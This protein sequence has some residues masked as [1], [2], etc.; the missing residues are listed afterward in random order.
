MKVFVCIDDKNGMMFNKRR[1][2][3]DRV[4]VEKIKEIANGKQIFASEY[5]KNILP[6]AT[7]C[8][9]F[10]DA[11]GFVF[12]E[13]PEGLF[14]NKIE[15]LYVFKWNRHYPSDRKFNMDLTNFKLVSTEDF[16]G[17]SHENITLEVYERK[18]G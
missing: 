10:E 5:S 9:N 11:N 14:E 16:A 18:E 17:Y 7:L 8:E 6:E 4:L 3:K 12:V 15:T 1:Q 13:N 2:S